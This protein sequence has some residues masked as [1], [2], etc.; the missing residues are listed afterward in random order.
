MQDDSLA[1]ELEQRIEALGFELV[2]L[3]QAGSRARPILRV[4]VDRPDSEPGKP[5]VTLDDCTHVSRALEP[6]LDGREGL[7]DRYVLEVSSPG[8]ERPL[9]RRRDWERF[10]GAEVAVRLREPLEGRGRRVQGTLVGLR[11]EDRVALRVQDDEVEFPLAGVER[12]N[13]VFRWE[14]G[15]KPR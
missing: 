1:R 5:S 6:W 10:G 8:V 4:S 2:E 3:E 7:S 14:R 12:A 13:L 11:G 9:V 15:Q